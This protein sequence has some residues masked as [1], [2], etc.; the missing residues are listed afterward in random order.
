MP[1]APEVTKNINHFFKES[2][3]LQN[4]PAKLAAHY[5]SWA[6]AYEIDVALEAYQGPS[7]VASILDTLDRAY[8]RVG[9][10]DLRV[11]DAGCGT[12]LVGME[13]SSLG[14]PKIDGIDLSGDMIDKAR[15]T[16][17]YASLSSGVDMNVG[18]TDVPTAAYDVTVCCGVFTPGHVKPAALGELIRVTKPNGMI[19][20]SAR[21]SFAEAGGL[22]AV[23]DRFIV[24]RQITMVFQLQDAHYVVDERACYWA[25]SVLPRQ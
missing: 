13:L 14:F 20:I 22:Q 15:N 24:E 2:Y 4:D 9:R 11:L 17:K 1:N 12:G 5:R 18:L 7:V 16:G 8:G 23:I 25:L 21:K 6:D 19:V 10:S 3:T